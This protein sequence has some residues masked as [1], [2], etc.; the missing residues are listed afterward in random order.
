MCY[1]GFPYL[2]STDNWFSQSS[3]S[4]WICGSVHAH[5]R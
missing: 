1:E 2:L 4:R 5:W 3:T